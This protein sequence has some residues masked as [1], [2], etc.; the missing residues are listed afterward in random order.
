VRVR[1]AA[2]RAQGSGAAPK[3]TEGVTQ[4]GSYALTTVGTGRG[5]EVPSGPFTCSARSTTDLLRE[6]VPISVV[7]KRLGHSK[8]STTSRYLA[9]VDVE[10][11]AAVA[12]MKLPRSLAG[13]KVQLRSKGTNA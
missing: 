8:V 1:K 9:V 10:R 4:L 2:P 7:G 11:H 13:V 6:H 12:T 5:R 3:D